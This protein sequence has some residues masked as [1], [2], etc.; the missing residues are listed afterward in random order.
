LQRRPDH[1]PV[2]P[3]LV[4]PEVVAQHHDVRRRRVVLVVSNVPAEGRNQAEARQ[5]STRDVRPVD[6]HRP[7]RAGEREAIRAEALRE[8]DAGELP[9]ALDVGLGHG[10]PAPALLLVLGPEHVH[11]IGLR[12]REG[13]QQDPIHQAEDRRG[14]TDPQRQAQYRGHRK[15]RLPDQRADS[16]LDILQYSAQCRALLSGRR[17]TRVVCMISARPTG[18]GNRACSDG[19]GRDV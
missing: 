3:E 2:A 1:A 6:L 13:P 9:S 16:E 18:R 19:S 17:S 8:G 4:L 15:A 10:G 11:A 7:V 12:V 5:D 14:G